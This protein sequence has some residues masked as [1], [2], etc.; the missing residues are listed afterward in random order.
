M[1]KVNFERVVDAPSEQLTSL[2]DDVQSLNKELG[3][4]EFDLADPSTKDID[5]DSIF[6]KVS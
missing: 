2:I 3:A 5:I 4:I 6:D 1:G